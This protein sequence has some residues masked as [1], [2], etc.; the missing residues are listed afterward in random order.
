M[1]MAKWAPTHD[2][3]CGPVNN[4]V[5]FLEP[6]KPQDNRNMGRCNEEELYGLTVVTGNPYLNG[7][8]TMSDCS[9]P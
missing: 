5:K 9:V 1:E 6:G 8:S 7:H 2:G 4:R 3:A